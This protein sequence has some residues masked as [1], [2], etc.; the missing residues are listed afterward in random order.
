VTRELDATT[1]LDASDLKLLSDIKTH[2]WHVM[3]VF[4][5]ENQNGPNWA[6]SIGL[7]H[8]YG[9]PEVIVLGLPLKSCMSVVNEVGA[10]VKAGKQYT[11]GIEYD[12][13]LKAP[14]RCVFRPVEKADYRNHVGYA[15]WFYEDDEFPLLQC[16]WPDNAGNFSWDAACD[17]GVREAQSLLV[18]QA[19]SPT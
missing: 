10:H 14:Y 18:E 16:C 13:I 9:H 19:N 8:S 17:Q 11:A 3:G 5:R 15:R 6:F 4:P 2:G 12:D 7:F 1:G